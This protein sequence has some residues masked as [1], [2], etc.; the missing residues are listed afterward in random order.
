M[1]K[2]GIDVS[3]YQGEIDW[4]RVKSS[5][6]DFAMLRCAVGGKNAGVDRCFEKNARGC[7][8]AGMPFGAYLYS[9]ATD[10]AEALREAEMTAAAL[11]GI[12]LLYPVAMDVEDSCMASLGKEELT[13]II[14]AFCGEMEKRGYYVCIYASLSWFKNKM[15]LERLKRYDKWVAQWS[16]KCT[17][18]GDYG[19][20][21]YSSGGTVAGIGG[22]VDMNEAY[23]DYPEIIKNARL[24]NTAEKPAETAES[25]PLYA[26]TRI[27][28]H[29]VPIYFSAYTVEPAGRVSGI[30]YLYDGRSISG[31]LRITNSAA[32]VGKKPVWENVTGFA[33]EKIIREMMK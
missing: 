19:I 11:G 23:K 20:W 15:N 26:G 9:R 6:I 32:H 25:K 18:E 4:K 8:A 5:G 27:A 30:Y 24:N 1:A 21:Q 31:R 12:P 2:T 10:R 17:F 7:L 29:D 14:D 13:D 16:D 3:K 22:R 28:L 33:D